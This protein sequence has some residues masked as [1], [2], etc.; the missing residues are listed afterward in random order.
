M[1]NYHKIISSN[2]YVS[3]NDIDV[4]KLVD[5]ILRNHRDEFEEAYDMDKY[6]FQDLKECKTIAAV[7][8]VTGDDI[9]GVWQRVL[10]SI[11][12]SALLLLKKTPPSLGDISSHRLPKPKYAI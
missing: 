8:A 9:Q 7:E 4:E 10:A 6:S 2:N 5:Y 1:S 11:V 12:P 3:V